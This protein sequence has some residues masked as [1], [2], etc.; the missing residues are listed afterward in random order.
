MQKIVVGIAAMVFWNVANS[1]P[2]TGLDQFPFHSVDQE[3]AASLTTNIFQ[4][5]YPP[6]RYRVVE[7]DIQSLCSRLAILRKEEL[8][9]E[10]RYLTL[11]LFED[12]IVDIRPNNLP[13]CQLHNGVVGLIGNVRLH[14]NV[15]GHPVSGNL[16][17]QK[18]KGVAGNLHSSDWIIVIEFLDQQ[19]YH[20]IWETDESFAIAID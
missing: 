15:R 4:Q 20:V 7:I 12:V 3:L 6:K 2:E 1:N 17:F 16:G 9:G 19:P 14:G 13:I 5:D 10:I 11:T 18:G 8:S